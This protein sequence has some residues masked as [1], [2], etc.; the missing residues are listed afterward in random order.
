[1]MSNGRDVFAKVCDYIQNVAS[2]LPAVGVEGSQNLPVISRPLV[3]RH[4]QQRQQ[5]LLFRRFVWCTHAAKSATTG[6]IRRG[7]CRRGTKR[8]SSMVCLPC[9]LDGPVSR[10]L[11]FSPA[12]KSSSDRNRKRNAASREDGL[13]RLRKRD[14]ERVGL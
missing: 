3:M 1:M 11:Q 4:A 6:P 10:N 7:F 9:L 2:A 8:K 5:H 12:T 14:S 13:G